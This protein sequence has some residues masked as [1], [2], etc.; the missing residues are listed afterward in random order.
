MKKIVL[1]LILAAVSMSAMTGCGSAPKQGESSGSQE[2]SITEN[3]QIANPW[4][5]S[6]KQGVAEVTGFD[7]TAPDGASDISYSYMDEGAMAEMSYELDGA[8]WIY[9]AQ[10]TDRLTNISGLEEGWTSEEEGNV[11][12]MAANYYAYTVDDE[13][14]NDVQLV[15]WYDALNGVSYSL[16]ASGADLDGM[17]IQAYAENIYTIND[18]DQGEV[19]DDPEGDRENELNDYFL[20]THTRSSDESALTISDSG[21]GTFGVDLNITRLCSLE[22]GVGTFDDHKMT[23]VVRDPNGNEMSGVIY[24][25][26]DN[27][28]T[29]KITDSTW[30]YLQNDETIDGFGK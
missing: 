11:S 1:A 8:S 14:M 2:A 30:T 9:R 7:M 12:W 27:S 21:D 29:V 23:F 16:C 18:P 15:C 26:S 28:L 22:N 13:D 10:T 20:G 4:T 5:E 24:R 19:T 17:D 3:E 25:D 6:D